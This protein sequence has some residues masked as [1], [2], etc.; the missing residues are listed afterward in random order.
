M[1]KYTQ[2]QMTQPILI[3]VGLLAS[4]QGNFLFESCDCGVKSSGTKGG[5]DK[6]VFDMYQKCATAVV[7]RRY[8]SKYRLLT[9]PVVDIPLITEFYHIF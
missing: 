8:P 4:C 7:K 6:K 9:I 3:K 2:H 5:S 1:I